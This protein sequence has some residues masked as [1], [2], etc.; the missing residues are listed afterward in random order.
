MVGGACFSH[1]LLPSTATGETVSE[2]NRLANSSIMDQITIK[3]GPLLFSFA[4][5]RAL[6]SI[7]NTIIDQHRQTTA[8]WNGSLMGER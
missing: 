2:S 8:E 3:V 4:L 7:V 6:E 1:L 5:S